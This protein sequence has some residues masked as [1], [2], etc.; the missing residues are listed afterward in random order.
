MVMGDSYRIPQMALNGQ[1]L[2]A[3]QD[4]IASCQRLLR[5]IGHPG[6]RAVIERILADEVAHLVMFEKAFARASAIE[7]GL[8]Q[9]LGPCG[10]LERVLMHPLPPKTG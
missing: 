4:A 3:E 10:S 2:Q 7:K 5:Q 6:V 8:R 9:I 1:F